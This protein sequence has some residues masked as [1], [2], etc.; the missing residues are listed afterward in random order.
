MASDLTQ[1]TFDHMQEVLRKL[2][3]KYGFAPGKADLLA[4]IHSE[5]T[6]DGVNSHGINRVPLFIT[7]VEK[8]YIDINAEAEKVESFGSIER[9]DGQLGPGII[10]AIK[11]TDR[12]VE[13]AKTHGMGLV[14]LRNTNHWMRGG[15][16]GWHAADQGCISIMFTNTQPNMPPWGGKESR[17]GNNPFIVSI[18]REE[19]HVV[20]DMAISQ[21]AFGKINDYRLKGKKLPF[22]GGYDDK[23]QLSTDPE[24][25]LLKE[26]GLP[27][28]YWKGSALSMILDMLATLLS[29]GNSTSKI[30][31]KDREVGISQVYLC[32]SQE[33]FHDKGLQERLLQEIIDYTHDVEPINEGDKVYYPGERTLQTRTKNKKEGMPVS[34]EVWT[35]VIEL[36]S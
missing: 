25:I 2:F 32:I 35:K 21:F 1:I 33:L 30:S 11:C 24:K 34:H 10:N 8:G 23:D 19:G 6:L 31:G 26:R 29:A 22:P 12:A 27:I 18:P 36:A 9:W 4:K 7:Y 17:L 15:T 5:S 3:L 20:L 13:L 16:Y 14:A 28:G